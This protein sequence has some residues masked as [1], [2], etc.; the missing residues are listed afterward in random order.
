M[1]PWQDDIGYVLYLYLCA[2][3]PIRAAFIGFPVEES[4]FAG[5]GQTPHCVGAGRVFT[6]VLQAIE[7]GLAC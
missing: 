7:I 2:F 5:A 6:A 3:I 4:G 1:N